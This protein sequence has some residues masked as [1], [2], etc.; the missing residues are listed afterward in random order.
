MEK[1]GRKLKIH[2]S[3]I[4]VEDFEKYWHPEFADAIVLALKSG[5]DKYEV[6]N[7]LEPQTYGMEHDRHHS[8]MWRHWEA[9]FIH[10]LDECSGLLSVCHL[11]ARALQSYVRKVRNITYEEEK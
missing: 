11:A 10:K 1:H 2:T 4:S 6:N 9:S 5:K 7:W 8:S 3:K